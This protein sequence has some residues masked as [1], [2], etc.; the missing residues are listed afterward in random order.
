MKSVRA[1]LQDKQVEDV[2]DVMQKGCEARIQTLIDELDAMS[3]RSESIKKRVEKASHAALTAGKHQ[4]AIADAPVD[5]TS[6][7]S[8]FRS[9]SSSA[10][11]AR[12]DTVAIPKVSS[13]VSSARSRSADPDDIGVPAG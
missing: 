4:A 5:T 12:V 1:M 2:T 13:T 11:D 10:S 9:H 3:I 7:L 6:F 8:S